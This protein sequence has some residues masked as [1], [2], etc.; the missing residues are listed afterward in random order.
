MLSQVHQRHCD[1][2]LSPVLTSIYQW[3]TG[4]KKGRVLR[5]DI[6]TSIFSR[7]FP[8]PWHGALIGSLQLSIQLWI[9][10][11]RYPS[12][13]GSPRQ[14]G[15]S[16]T[17]HFHTWPTLGIEPRTSRSRAQCLNQLRYELLG[18]M[19]SSLPFERNSK[20][21]GNKAPHLSSCCNFS[22]YIYTILVIISLS[23][24]VAMQPWPSR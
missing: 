8:Y 15:F 21:L 13:L 16:Y 14:C 10:F 4:K 17:Q 9:C 20:Y 2:D 22:L 5:S 3:Q 19:H 12:Q 23:S 6:Y 24:S 1:Q 7:P 11:T 18:Y